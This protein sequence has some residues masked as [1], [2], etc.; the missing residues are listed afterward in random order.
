[1]KTIL[2]T[3]AAGYIGRHVVK[4]ALDM[5]YRV[6]ASDFAFK[7]VD[8]RAEF[9]DVPIFSGDKNIYA[10]LGKPDVC[11][12]MAWRDG[13]RHNAPSHM[14]DLSSH[15]TFLNNMAAGGLSDLTVMG[16]MHEVGYWEGAIEDDT[17]CNP[18]SQYG[19][20][21]NAL[22]QS[23]MLSLQGSSCNL[24][25]LRAYYITGDE[26]HG[27]SIFAKIAQA[28]VQGGPAG[29]AAEAAVQYRKEVLVVAIA[30]MLLPVL[31]LIML[32]GAIFGTLTQ[33]STAVNDDLEIAANVI[34]LRNAVSDILQEAY[35]DTLAEIES[36]R[37]SRTYSDI[38]DS[39]GGHVSYNAFQLISM[40]CAYQGED[41]YT[42]ISLSN[43]SE[44][45]QAHRT[46]YYT[47]TIS[48]EVRTEPV[49]KEV[50]GQTIT[51]QEDHTYTVFTL[52]YL[53]DD[54]FADTVWQL[55][56]KQ[57]S[58]A[59]AYAH[60]LTVYLHE[61]EEREGIS[62]LGQINDSLIDDNSPAP[63]GGFGNPFNDPNWEQHITSFFGKRE[64]VGIPGKDTTIH[65]GLDI[66]Y[67]YGTP[68]LAVEAGTVIK[69]G[70][71]VSY[72]NYLVINH[73][74][75]YCTLYAH[76]S[77]LLAQVGDTVNKYDTI[78]KVGATG[79][80][81]GNHLHICVIINGF[82]VNPKD[83]LN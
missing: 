12:H 8:E 11:I 33:P 49:Q 28:G 46:E 27:S 56:D 73:G 57:K 70:Y 80:V 25:W 36:E 24:H 77:Q 69:A 55:D 82:Y 4:K 79:D 52:S 48:E 78:A 15:V 76:C 34:Q 2:V 59:D 41:D 29:A 75:G 42:K 3:G 21:K 64:D 54:Y 30:V 20:A 7:G 31:V 19:I 32:P 5:G 10:A 23:M 62:I 67:P 35:E 65:N 39:V 17:P 66:A 81:T 43:L 74:G 60:N 26:A 68:I 72:G 50:R 40:Y 6:I 83:Y 53:G 18:L 16:T 45:I 58:Y 47:Y 71:H 61:I 14:K 44:Q 22:R 38:D 13:F 1:M 51:V 9:C 63:S 37:A